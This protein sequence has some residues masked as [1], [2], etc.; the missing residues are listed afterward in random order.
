[1]VE[2]SADYYTCIVDHDYCQNSR[3]ASLQVSP[4]D[5]QSG[6]PTAQSKVGTSDCLSNDEAG[7]MLKSLLL[8]ENLNA[9]LK[10]QMAAERRRHARKVS[11]NLDVI[12]MEIEE[13]EM[14][15]Y[16]RFENEKD[17]IGDAHVIGGI[18]V[19]LPLPPL[20]PLDQLP[21]DHELRAL[22]E[23]GSTDSNDSVRPTNDMNVILN[24]VKNIYKK[25]EESNSPTPLT[26]SVP[27]PS[28]PLKSSRS[29]RPPRRE[30][31]ETN[32][33]DKMPGYFTALRKAPKP[34]KSK[35]D[36]HHASLSS[37]VPSHD[38]DPS[39][40]RDVGFSK[41]PSYLCFTNSTKYDGSDDVEPPP[42]TNP[43]TT[44]TPTF[45]RI[46][47]NPSPSTTNT[48]NPTPT[49]NIA[50]PTPPSNPIPTH[51]PVQ[52]DPHPNFNPE[53]VT[54][55]D[56]TPSSRSETPCLYIASRANSESRPT[57]RAPSRTSSPS[58]RS[59]SASS[60]S[61]ESQRGS[62]SSSREES[63]SPSPDRARQS[64]GRTVRQRNYRRKRHS[65]SSS[66]SSS[67]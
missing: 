21:K 58:S 34:E 1:M 56:S 63:C 50:N 48:R 49:N 57:S 8:K 14:P 40:E 44:S 6:S 25:R 26:I 31:E 39:P 12:D 29:S 46:P 33:Y 37:A 7:S 3:P 22:G 10:K 2:V 13:P 5:S 32:L 51:N 9:E 36:A 15:R 42:T 64:R 60:S 30:K 16:S 19:G 52:E 65:Y 35:S 54:P 47:R 27:K 43:A 59:S 61:S 41:L 53:T 66:H 38:R 67:R 18:A 28:R 55:I 20:P 45:T 17:S 4:A 11:V 62:G 24:K 23:S